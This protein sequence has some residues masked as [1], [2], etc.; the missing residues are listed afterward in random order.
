MHSAALLTI[1]STS[2]GQ[3]L[4]AINPLVIYIVDFQVILNVEE[5]TVAS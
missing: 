1:V 3:V 2:N 4:M 5:L